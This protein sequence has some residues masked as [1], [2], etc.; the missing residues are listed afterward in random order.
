M[1]LMSTHTI[2]FHTEIRKIF[3]WYPLLSRAMLWPAVWSE[4]FLFAN[5]FY[6]ILW[7]CKWTTKAL[8]RLCGCTGWSGPSMSICYKDS[9]PLIWYISVLLLFFFL[10]IIIFAFAFSFVSYNIKP[11]LAP[12]VF[13]F[14]FFFFFFCHSLSPP[15]AVFVS[16]IP[17]HCFTTETIF[18]TMGHTLSTHYK[19]YQIV[20]Y[21]WKKREND[22]KD[23]V[24][25]QTISSPIF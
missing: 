21:L 19:L 11:R 13:A 10:Q 3:I 9:F 8:M 1:L 16:W 14:F 22:R 20:L 15:V 12:V 2:R 25:R 17:C 5:I 4:P 18:S 24:W 7:F 6:S 23:R